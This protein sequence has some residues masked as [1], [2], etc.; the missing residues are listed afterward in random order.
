MEHALLDLGASVNLISF[1]GYQKLGL[2]ELKPTSITLQLADH[3]VREPRGIVEDVLVK[4]EQFYYPVDFIVLDYQLVLHP[5]THTPI[6]LGRTFIATANALINC[7]NGRM[8]LTFGSMTLELNIFHMTKQPH[9]DDDCA[10][11][12]LIGAV[13]EFNKNCFSGSLETLLNNSVGSYDLECDIHV[14]ENFSMMDSSQ[15]LEEQQMMAIN[16]GWKPCFEELL[17]NKKKLVHSS[18]EAPQLELKLLPDGL[19]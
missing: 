12:N 18:E 8:Q 19:K 4:I 5:S 11:V 15:V 9:E 6:I 10:Y 3:F 17:E 2:G 13:E 14:S 16:K 1:S 7:R